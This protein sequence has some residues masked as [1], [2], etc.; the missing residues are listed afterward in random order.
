MALEWRY[1]IDLPPVGTPRPQF[2]R[3]STGKTIT[4]YPQHYTDYL[5][6]VQRLLEEDGALD[7][8]FFDVMAAPMGVKAEIK[9]FVKAPKNL[10]KLKNIMRTTAPDIDNLEKAAFDSIFKGLKVKDSRIV[11]V[12]KAKF[13]EIDH[14]RTEIVL[15][16]IE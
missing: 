7:D 5:N 15:K 12:A 4:Y 2:T 14:P 8:T 13:Q 3:T 16:G 11:M 6:T 10:K 9:F 1:I